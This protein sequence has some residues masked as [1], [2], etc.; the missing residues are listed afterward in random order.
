MT[1]TIIG[2]IITGIAIEI[3]RLTH[4]QHFGLPWIALVGVLTVIASLIS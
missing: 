2:I 1:T 3:D 4:Y